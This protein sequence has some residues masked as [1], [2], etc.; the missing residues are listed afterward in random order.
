MTDYVEIEDFSE[1]IKEKYNSS[2]SII[3]ENKTNLFLKHSVCEFDIKKR[4]IRKKR[5]LFVLF[6]NRI[7]G[8]K[9]P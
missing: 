8:P 3:N 5:Y 2:Y 7:G 1:F 6:V 4:N 9:R